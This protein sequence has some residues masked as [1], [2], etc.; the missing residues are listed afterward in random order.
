MVKIIWTDQSLDDVDSIADFIAK[1]SLKY[2]KIQVRRF[3]DRVELLKSHPK[4][5]RIVPELEN[6]LI[7]ELIIGNYRII[8]KIRSKERIDILTVHHSRGRLTGIL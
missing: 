2:A 5:G 6:K 7:R 1:D 3:F 8:Y 4:A